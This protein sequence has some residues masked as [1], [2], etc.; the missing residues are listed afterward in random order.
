MGARAQAPILLR[1]FAENTIRV[2]SVCHAQAWCWGVAAER[3]RRTVT[4]SESSQ[5]R[6]V[7]T[8]GGTRGLCR[9]QGT[10]QGAVGETRTRRL[11]LGESGGASQTRRVGVDTAEVR[12]SVPGRRSHRAEARAVEEVTPGCVSG[13]GAKSWGLSGR[14]LV[15]IC[16]LR[17][18][19]LPPELPAYML[20][21]HP[22][23][24]V[25]W[26]S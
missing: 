22:R 23:F 15:V 8:D 16:T 9:G 17:T 12:R 10:E 6:R 18:P 3:P 14:V 24:D 26:V 13:T 1:L 19:D 7:Q 11:S 21:Q 4:A 25:Q 2:P 20:T 5:G